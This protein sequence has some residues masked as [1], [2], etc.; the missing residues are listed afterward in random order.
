MK[1]KSGLST[2]KSMLSARTYVECRRL[3]FHQALVC[4]WFASLSLDSCEYGFVKLVPQ[5]PTDRRIVNGSSDIDSH[6]ALTFLPTG[7]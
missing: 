7:K 2:G 3:G 5:L 4:Y 1:S 6:Q